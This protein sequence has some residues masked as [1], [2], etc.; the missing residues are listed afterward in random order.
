MKSEKKYNEMIYKWSNGDNCNMKE[1]FVLLDESYLSAIADLYQSAFMGAPWNDD[2]S[3]RSQLEE[4]L[5][6]VACYFKGMLRP[7]Y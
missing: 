5:R 2:W 6:D 3:D 7:M 1:E 4:Y